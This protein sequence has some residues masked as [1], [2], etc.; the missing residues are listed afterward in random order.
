ME[1]HL[2]PRETEINAGYKKNL[3]LSP[4]D[5]EQLTGEEFCSSREVGR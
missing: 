1:P 5:D 2:A 3:F 4:S